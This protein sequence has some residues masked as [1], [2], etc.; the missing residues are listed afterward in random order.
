MRRGAIG[1]G[2][3]IVFIAMVLVAAVAAGVLIST[4][5][6]LQQKAMATGRE[7]TQE[8]ASGIKV[9]NIYGYVYGNPPSGHN[10]TRLV[11]YVSPNAGSGGI[12]LA[13][14]KVVIS[15]GKQMAVF[16]YYNP[17][18]D[19]N[20]SGV[21]VNA[22]Y[23]HYAGDIENIFQ[24][25]TSYLPYGNKSTTLKVADNITQLWENLYNATVNGHLIFGIVAVQDYDGSISDNPDNPTL[26]WGDIAALLVWMTPF[27]GG[28]KFGLPPATKVTG[29]V[30]PENGAGGVI[31]FTTP[32]TY[33]QNIIQLQ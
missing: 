14:V 25:N 16:R 27:K 33:T 5:G 3:L 28:D 20:I 26:S 13:H 30:I 19:E 10:I 18:E 23:F 2:T 11:I 21:K 32:N 24:Y 4:S 15:N 8:V 9:M 1:I 31:D 22:T 6:Y 7:T 17:S 29:K 12:N